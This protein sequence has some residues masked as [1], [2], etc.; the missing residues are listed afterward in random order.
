MNSKQMFARC[1]V[2]LVLAASASTASAQPYPGKPIRMIVPFTPGSAT[3]IV[4]RVVSEKLS[5]SLG[6]PVVVEN[7]PGAGGTIGSAMVAAAAA[8]GYTVLVQSSSHTVNP[9]IYPKLS[10]DTANDFAGVTPLVMLP[11]V[12][13]T[14]PGK[15]IKSVKDLVER[16][17]AQPGRLTYASA[18][19]GSATHMNAEKFRVAARIEAVHVPFKGTMEGITEVT[20]GR[21]DYFFAPVISAL[22]GIRDGRIRALAVGSPTRSSVLPDVQTTQEAGVAGSD[23]T[24]WIGL[25]VH[26]KTSRNIVARLNEETLKALGS[27]DVRERLTKLG[28]EPFTMKPEEFDVYIR[29]ELPANAA[30]AKTAAITAN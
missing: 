17:K 30:I 23:Y 11:N 4:A 21:V 7:K 20:T 28:A 19:S 13:I 8:D 1:A 24:F 9:A 5:A 29:K 25:L 14:M 2:A 10:Y 26:A 12:L 27:P 15:G 16:A 6:Q 22:P 18:G 3:D